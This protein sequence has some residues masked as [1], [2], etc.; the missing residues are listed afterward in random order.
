MHL[1]AITGSCSD[2]AWCRCRMSRVSSVQT[3]GYTQDNP[4]VCPPPDTAHISALS[5]RISFGCCRISVQNQEWFSMQWQWG[6]QC[7]M[8]LSAHYTAGCGVVCVR[9]HAGIRAAGRR[10]PAHT[11]SILLVSSHPGFTLHLHLPAHL[12]Q[13]HLQPAPAGDLKQLLGMKMK[14]VPGY[15]DETAGLS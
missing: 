11:I 7:C 4:C 14:I 9:A 2:T 1:T 5:P 6:L 3:S 8:Q 10:F 15:E 13:A 12:T